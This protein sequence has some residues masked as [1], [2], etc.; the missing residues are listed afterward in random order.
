M[1]ISSGANVVFNVKPEHAEP[2]MEDTSSLC[3]ASAEMRTRW[4]EISG[5]R[6]RSQSY[7]VRVPEWELWGPANWEA[8]SKYIG[9]K[10]KDRKAYAESEKRKG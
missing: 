10:I 6:I 1:L 3:K 9:V 5:L 4:E 2:W 7:S 8:N